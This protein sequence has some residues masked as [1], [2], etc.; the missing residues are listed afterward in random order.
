[1]MLS[2]RNK[3]AIVCGG[4]DGIGRSTAQLLAS[5]GCEVTLIARNQEKLERVKS[6]LQT[7]HDQIHQA[8]CADFNNPNSLKEKVKIHIDSLDKV[9]DILINN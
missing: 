5:L 1:M 7:N 3:H 4:T 9:V 2:F 8:V 6:S